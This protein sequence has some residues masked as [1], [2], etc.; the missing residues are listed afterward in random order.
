MKSLK[1]NIH[2]L[3]KLGTE[4]IV[5]DVHLMAIRWLSDVHPMCFGVNGPL[6]KP[7]RLVHTKLKLQPTGFR[8][9]ADWK[10][11]LGYIGFVL[12]HSHQFLNQKSV[13]SQPEAYRLWF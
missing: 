4:P 13:C 9:A 3:E 10:M 1:N 2:P 8:L 12:F 5:S 6:Q 11:Q 7:L